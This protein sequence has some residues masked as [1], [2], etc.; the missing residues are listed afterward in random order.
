MTARIYQVLGVFD[1]LVYLHPLWMVTCL[2]SPSR[3]PRRDVRCGARMD[4]GKEA[5][6]PRGI[7]KQLEKHSVRHPEPFAAAS[8]YEN[9]GSE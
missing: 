4:Q 9:G 6:I 3:P 5:P 7:R 8:D 2:W 1:D